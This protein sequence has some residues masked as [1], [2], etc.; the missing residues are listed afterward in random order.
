MVLRKDKASESLL[1]S[2]NTRHPVCHVSK[3]PRDEW[4]EDKVDLAHSVDYLMME[5]ISSFG[6]LELGGVFVG[7]DAS[8]AKKLRELTYAP[9]IRRLKKEEPTPNE[10]PLTDRQEATN[11]L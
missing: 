9:G 7:V 6:E 2:L 4:K 10:V 8:S 11:D 5:S 3:K 1:K